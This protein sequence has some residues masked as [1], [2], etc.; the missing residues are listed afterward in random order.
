MTSTAKR[1]RLALS[2]RKNRCSSGLVGEALRVSR[3]QT[4]PVSFAS[5]TLWACED[6]SGMGSCKA[7]SSV[8]GKSTAKN[9]AASRGKQNRG[10]TPLSCTLCQLL[11]F[12]LQHGTQQQ[13]EFLNKSVFDN[14]H[15]H[16]GVTVVLC[17][18]SYDCA[19]DGSEPSV[20][21]TVRQSHCKTD[22]RGKLHASRQTKVET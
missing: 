2:P 5:F 17:L 14:L 20:H 11:F 7:C 16:T 13:A 1:Y 18:I 12:L 22:R 4:T 19:V 6:L 3:R 8:G 10:R 9:Q 21:R 15:S